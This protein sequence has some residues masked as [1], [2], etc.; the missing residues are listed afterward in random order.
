MNRQIFAL[1]LLSLFFA[2]LSYS[3]VP[4][5]VIAI[6]HAS[7]RP[8]VTDIDKQ[9]IGAA[10]VGDINLMQD[11]IVNQGA[12]VNAAYHSD[13]CTD[14]RENCRSWCDANTEW[15][16]ALYW[17]IRN[18][19][20]QA[21]KLLISHNISHTRFSEYKN[22]LA[23][24]IDYRRPTLVK[25]LLDNNVYK[26]CNT[27][28]HAINREHNASYGVRPKHLPSKKCVE[29]LEVLPSAHSDI[30]GDI[31]FNSSLDERRKLHWYRPLEAA[32]ITSCCMLAE[33]LIAQ[34][35]TITQDLARDTTIIK[36]QK[37]QAE[38]NQA[39]T[40][41]DPLKVIALLRSG[42]Y[43]NKIAKAYLN[44]KLFDL[45]KADNSTALI[46][47]LKNGCGLY[48]CDDKGNTL[49]HVAIENG[50]TNVACL[51]LYLLH[52]TQLIGKYLFKPN[53]A[54]LTP[55]ALAMQHEKANHPM[56]KALCGIKLPASTAR[57]WCTIS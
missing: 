12:N 34:N 10:K 19:H 49:L 32:S 51:L 48:A 7:T 46:N 11:L 25:L 14:C 24:A 26:K 54:G 30:N 15:S 27:L 53:N 22:P 17:A 29:I 21:V 4:G 13:E 33:F 9:L 41:N 36:A 23:T 5:Q 52:K 37:N 16:S 31:A 6:L 35:A 8:E 43:C 38:L 2:P 28:R 40:D 47:L 3:M 57:G 18:G 20:D 56:I 44:Q 39:V 1:I 42:V 55:F 45:A 50:S